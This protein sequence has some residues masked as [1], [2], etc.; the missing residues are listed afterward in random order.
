[1]PSVQGYKRGGSIAMQEDNKNYRAQLKG[2]QD[3][4]KELIRTTRSLNKLVNSQRR[5]RSRYV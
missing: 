4:Q 1:M 5:I 3:I 2:I